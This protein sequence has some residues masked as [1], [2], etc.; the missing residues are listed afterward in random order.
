VHTITEHPVCGTLD[1]APARSLQRIAKMAA[2]LVAAAGPATVIMSLPLARYVV[3]PC[4]NDESHVDNF[5]A[6]DFE[7]TL[8]AGVATVREALESLSSGQTRPSSI[9]IPTQFSAVTTCAT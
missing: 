4:C 6:R 2:D 1:V 7:T 3:M 5:G 8:R 9:W